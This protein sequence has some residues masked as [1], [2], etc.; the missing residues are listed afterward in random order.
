MNAN[1]ECYRALEDLEREKNIPKEYML[2]KI[3]AAIASTIKRDKN[4]PADNV[5]VI[6]NEEKENIK[7]CIKKDI[8]E[9]VENPQT[10][11]SLEEAKQISRR[12]KLGD[13]AMLEVDPSAVGRIA[14]KVGKNVIVQAINEAVNGSVIQA[15]EERQ[16][17]LMSGTV[18][19][20]DPKSGTV[21]VEVNGHELPLFPREQIPGESFEPDDVIRLYVSVGQPNLR[22]GSTA[23][24]VMLSRT[25]PKFVEKLFEVEVPEIA[26]GVVEIK[27]VSREA[28]SRSKVAVRSNDPNVDAVGSCIGPKRSRINTI[29]EDLA[30]ERIDLI[31]YSEDPGEFVAAALSPAEVRLL[32]IDNEQKSCKVVVG[33][34]QLSL[35]IGKTGQNVRLA[36]RL[37]GYRI[38]ILSE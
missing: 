12:Y 24:E 21:M 17:S 3:K 23:K 4:V 10:E 25:T 8:V 2:D 30:G 14:A 1:K 32:E 9:T 36:A 20:V 16:G 31:K 11:I 18:R 7:V 13:V 38:D 29:L 27:G 28:G 34:D 15:F 26:S 33:A 19:S 37:T 22:R 5:E 35:A 6:F